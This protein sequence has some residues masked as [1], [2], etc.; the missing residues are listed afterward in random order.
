MNR[1]AILGIAGVCALILIGYS[2]AAWYEGNKLRIAFGEQANSLQTILPLLMLEGEH[3]DQ[4]IFSSEQSATLTARIPLFLP[5]QSYTLKSRI[6]HLPLSRLLNLKKAIIDSTLSADP[7]STSSNTSNGTRTLPITIHTELGFNG[8]GTATITV[9]A[10]ESSDVSRSSITI[11][12]EFKS[13]LSRF[14]FKGG[15]Q[16]I[17]VDGDKFKLHISDLDFMSSRSRIFSDEPTIYDGDDHIT[18]SH[19]GNSGANDPT[20][21]ASGEPPRVLWRLFGLS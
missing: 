2:G 17:V 7:D 21:L 19:I 3:Y 13:D 15:T 6:Q 10:L 9:P 12:A 4:G 16:D 20:D 5:S 14:A 8:E 18:I 1:T 11:Q